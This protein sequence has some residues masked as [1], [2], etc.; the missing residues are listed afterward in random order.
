MS[1]I[2]RTWQV[3][4]RGKWK[5]PLAK[6]ELEKVMIPLVGVPSTIAAGLSAYRLRGEHPESFL[7]PQ[8]RYRNQEVKEC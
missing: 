4:N 8:V 3:I 5:H 7:S 2:Y 1:L 6:S